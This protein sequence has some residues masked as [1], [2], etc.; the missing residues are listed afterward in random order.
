MIDFDKLQ[1]SELEHFFGG[2]GIVKAKMYVDEHGKIMKAVLEKGVSIGTHTHE[3]S[4][5]TCY[6]ISGTGKY[7][8]DGQTEYVRAGE[9]HFCPKGSTHTVINEEDEPLVVFCVVPNL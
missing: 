9:C 2:E 6:V 5:E 8:L 1:T 4:S 3:T 7:T